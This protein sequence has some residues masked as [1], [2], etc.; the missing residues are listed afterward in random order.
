MRPVGG[1]EQAVAVRGHFAQG[2]DTNTATATGAWDNYCFVYKGEFKPDA[3]LSPNLVK[4]NDDFPDVGV[5]G[6]AKLPLDA[7]PTTYTLVVTGYGRPNAGAYSATVA[8]PGD[9]AKQA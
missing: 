5:C 3:A 7:W 6:F 9:V 4:G 1:E 8:G 2:I